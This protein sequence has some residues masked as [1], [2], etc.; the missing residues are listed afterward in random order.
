MPD[1][2]LNQITTDVPGNVSAYED[3]LRIQRTNWGVSTEVILRRLVDAGRLRT[4]Q[5]EAYRHWKAE[6]PVPQLDEGGSRAYRYREPI[7]LF[8]QR[9]VRTVLDALN[10]D[11]ITLHKASG[12]LD[13]LKIGDVRQ[14]EKHIAGI[15]RLQHH[16]RVG[17]LPAKAVP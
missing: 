10:S 8:G 16:P 3:W 17:S 7:H 4:S 14:L 15:L 2:F 9:Y 6:Q 1:A 12:F 5:Y 13:N 11:R